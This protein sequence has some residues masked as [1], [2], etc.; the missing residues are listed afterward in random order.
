MSEKEYLEPAK[1]MEMQIK[2]LTLQAS[3]K[4]EPLADFITT[5]DAAVAYAQEHGGMSEPTQRSLEGFREMATRLI[6]VTEVRMNQ[7]VVGA[8]E[9]VRKTQKEQDNG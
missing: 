4:R 3:L 2:L 5:I 6:A 8:R 7:D 1:Y 9:T